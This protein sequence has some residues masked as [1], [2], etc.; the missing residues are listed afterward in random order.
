MAKLGSIIRHEYTTIVKQ[1]SFWIVMLAIPLLISV[2]FALVYFG[3]KAS[4]DRINEIASEL[5]NVAILDDS[6]LINKDVAT[7]AE[8]TISPAGQLE[9]L[10]EQVRTAEKEALIYYPTSL[11]ADRQYHIYLSSNDFTKSNS[12][13]ALAS[14]LLKTSL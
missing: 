8:L 13:S 6:G 1:P 5:K 2:V 12:V 7:A 4:E 3:N 10:K 9:E 11:E 14:N